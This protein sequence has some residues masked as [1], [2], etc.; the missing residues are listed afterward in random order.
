[1]KTPSRNPAP[2]PCTQSEADAELRNAAVAEYDYVLGVVKNRYPDRNEGWYVDIVQ[3]AYVQALAR[4]D[5]FQGASSIRTWLVSIA[6]RHVLTDARKEGVR[7][8]FSNP[9][10]VDVYETNMADDN[11]AQSTLEQMV[12]MEDGALV[13]ACMAK[14]SERAR[15]VLTMRYWQNL[16]GKKMAAALKQNERTVKTWLHRAKQELL[17][18]MNI[19][20]TRTP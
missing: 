19:G 10:N 8:Q 16:D 14:L 5:G 12:G 13:R 20:S 3:Q 9:G 4:L 11:G 6:L 18:L 17:E 15:Q 7:P 2:A 1:M